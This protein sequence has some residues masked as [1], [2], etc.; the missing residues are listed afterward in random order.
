MNAAALPV[1][2][3]LTVL[4]AVKTDSPTGVAYHA[5]GGRPLKIEL[6]VE[7][8]VG[9]PVD[10]RADLFQK[11]ESLLAPLQKDI[12]VAQAV[13]SDG[14]PSGRALV[15]WE[16]AVPEVKRETKMLV[17]LKSKSASGEWVSAGQFLFAA[18]PPGFADEAL[19]GIS[20]DRPIHMFGENKN[21]RAFLKTKKLAFD[22][23]L[24]GL[25]S[26]PVDP[27]A[28]AIYI[29]EAAA[30]DLSAWLAAHSGWRG[31]LVVFCP[32]ATSMPGVFVT[33]RGGLRLAKVTLPLLNS[34][35]NDPLSQKTFVEIL[36]TN[37]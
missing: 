30:A 26:L 29:G 21:L 27:D 37:Q 11:G 32:D 3:L 8:P 19:A 25:S 22:D 36:N 14:Q 16:L 4:G 9:V 35:S 12:L 23:D 33:V 34:L 28:K 31:N 18:Y 6:A 5:F 10:I 2:I 13:R 15:A 17:R 20:K 7:V 1:V 24:E